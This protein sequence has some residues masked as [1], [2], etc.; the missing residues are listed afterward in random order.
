MFQSSDEV[1]HDIG[2]RGLSCIVLYGF[3]VFC[4][5]DAFV[6]VQS[7]AVGGL[8]GSNLSQIDVKLCSNRAQFMM[9]KLFRAYLCG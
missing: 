8:P 9:K 4:A 5:Q 7:S 2:G 6:Q 1:W 3:F